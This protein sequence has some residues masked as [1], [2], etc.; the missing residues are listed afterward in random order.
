MP[1]PRVQ[2]IVDDITSGPWLY[3]RHVR[4]PSPELD[5][6]CLVEVLDRQQR[7]VGHGLYNPA[8]DIRVRFLSRGRRSD[9]L[10]PREFLLK[11]LKAADRLRRHTLRLP[12]VT[13]AYRIVHAEGDDLSGLIVDKLG[14]VIVCQYH[15][16]GFW[17]LR[18]EVE[19]AMRELYPLATVIH[20]VPKSARNREAFPDT[21]EQRETDPRWIRENSVDYLVAPGRDHKTGWFCDQ[22]DNRLRVAGLAAGRTVLDLC[23][24]AG[25]FSLQAARLG[26]SA[27]D[28]VDLDEKV[29]ARAQ[30]SAERGGATIDFH[31]ADA[32]HFLR[33][34]RSNSRQFQIVV[35]DPHK[36]VPTKTHLREGLKS[37]LDL[38]ALALEAVKPGG[39][40]ATFS[41]SGSLD[42]PGFLGVLFQAARRAHR[43][44]R[45]LEILGAAADHPQRP[46][47]AK[48]RY[49]KGVI[50]AV[51]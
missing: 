31:H 8:S 47:F 18:E 42:L 32:F 4:Q 25:G 20:S 9:L 21:G 50:L 17:R 13:D 6:G 44:I 43:D 41:C 12:E 33:D 10:R 35:V 22:R 1:L 26:A 51:D 45:V 3:G 11:K 28:A 29:L 5:R 38:N 39:L 48:S 2:L 36:F 23:C 19:W 40:L 46:D 49:L 24:N 14:D 37:Y 16:L 34:L 15:A 7:F 27:V 30:A